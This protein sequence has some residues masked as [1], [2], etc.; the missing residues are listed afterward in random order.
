MRGWIGIYLNE[1]VNSIL[2]GVPDMGRSPR[3]AA[4][5]FAVH[6]APAAQQ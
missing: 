2:A 4:A 1:L 5:A 6:F 3:C